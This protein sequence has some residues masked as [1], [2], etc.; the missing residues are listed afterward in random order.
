MTFFIRD[1]DGMEHHELLHY[2]NSFAPEVFPPL[3]SRHFARGM[4]WIAQEH[5]TNMAIGFAGL[6]PMEPFV[7]VAYMKRAYVLP[8]YR[9]QG[10]QSEFLRVREKTARELG[11]HQLVTECKEQNE[12]S[13]KNI[14]AAGFKQCFPEQ[15]WGEAGSIYFSK[16]L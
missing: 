4:W 12:F 11:W 10:I 9:G 14:L 7:G 3:Q 16:R 6:T 15:P 13:A 8:K 1:I 5:E 2:M